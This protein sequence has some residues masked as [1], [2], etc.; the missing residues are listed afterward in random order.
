MAPDGAVFVRR[1]GEDRAL[2]AER[3]GV[4]GQV[5]HGFPVDRVAQRPDVVRPGPHAHVSGVCIAVAVVEG[6]PD[7]DD[8][9]IFAERDGRAGLV[10]RRLADEVGPALH[11]LALLPGQHARAP[12]VRRRA[13]G[14][15]I[16]IRAQRNGR[17]RRFIQVQAV[18]VRAALRP[19]HAVPRHHAHVPGIHSVAVVGSRPDSHDVAHAAE[20]HGGA[21]L[22]HHDLAPYIQAQLEPGLAVPGKDPRVSRVVACIVVPRCPDGEHG[23]VSVDRNR[24]ARKVALVRAD[25]LTALQPLA[26]GARPL[27]RAHGSRVALDVR[28]AHRD[29]RT[30]AAQGDRAPRQGARGGAVQVRAELG[31]RDGDDRGGGRRR[32]R[33]L[34]EA[35]ALARAD[36]QGV[37]VGAQRNRLAVQVRAE[38]GPRPAGPRVRANL[39]S[40]SDGDHGAVEAERHRPAR[41]DVAG[42]EL[43]AETRPRPG[44]QRV[45]ARHARRRVAVPGRSDG[46][47]G[48]RAG[49][50]DRGAGGVERVAVDILADA[51]PRLPGLPRLPSAPF[52]DADVSR[53]GAAAVVARRSD[54]DST[55]I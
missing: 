8:V 43:R 54:R 40:R 44:G 41:R 49:K 39:R 46:H 16:A 31:P 17:A 12:G 23:T 10:A 34:E 33:P 7:C 37:A 51:R 18:D 22:V 55:P 35:R 11:P 28:R 27:V 47:H 9:A 24:K 29:D 25:D 19:P 2:R 20:R 42:L 32:E 6:R 4:P 50:G 5:E 21:G 53:R 26:R 1:D 45:H 15:N 3:D 14:E 30:V 38:P 36:G 13:H 48:A 52:V